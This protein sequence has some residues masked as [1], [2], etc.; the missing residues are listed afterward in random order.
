MNFVQRAYIPGDRFGAMMSDYL[1]W[2]ISL[3]WSTRKFQSDSWS[4][5][6]D[7]S[8]RD[9]WNQIV[10]SRSWRWRGTYSSHL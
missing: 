10:R 4:E 2:G 1:Q 5:N 3:S 6:Q 7:S 8:Y 9:D